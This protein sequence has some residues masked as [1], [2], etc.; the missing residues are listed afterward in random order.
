LP[1]VDTGEIKYIEKTLAKDVATTR[2][3]ALVEI[4]KRIRPG[5]L[6]NTRKCARF[7]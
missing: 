6:A 3:E 2:N 5:D 7:N 4:Y 1:N